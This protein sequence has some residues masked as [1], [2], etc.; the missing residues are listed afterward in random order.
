MRALLLSLIL[1]STTAVAQDTLLTSVRKNIGEVFK[2]ES[3]C[4]SFY[5]AFEKVDVSANNILVGY[6]GA[7]LLGMARHDP[8]V[9]K[10]MGYFSD[11]KEL[12]EKSI[13]NDPQN[14]ELR[15]LRL[16]IQTH[17]PSFLGY[18]ENKEKDKAFVLANLD[19][20]PSELFRTKVRN[21]IKHAESEG[22]L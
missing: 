13:A 17:I 4:F 18:N 8:N 10:K 5:N 3:I 6:K 21:F 7:V 14:I 20:A 9:F 22:K 1:W 15:F 16:T 2:T 19:K 12:L 11:G